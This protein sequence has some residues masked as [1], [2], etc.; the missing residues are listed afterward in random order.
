MVYDWCKKVNHA[1][2]IDTNNGQAYNNI[3]GGR[4]HGAPFRGYGYV[5][6][7]NGGNVVTRIGT[8]QQQQYY[9]KGKKYRYFKENFQCP[10]QQK[11]K[12]DNNKIK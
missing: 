9:R 6:L 10:L 1:Q 7:R 3:I 4:T 2:K 12:N 5:P 8:Q 11:K